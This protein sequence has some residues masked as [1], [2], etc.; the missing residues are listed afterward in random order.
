MRMWNLAWVQGVVLAVEEVRGVVAGEVVLGVVASQR[1]WWWFRHGMCDEL[2]GD[3][4][5][6]V[7]GMLR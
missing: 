1:G 4:Q 7:R 5:Q 3:Q 6:G 2:G